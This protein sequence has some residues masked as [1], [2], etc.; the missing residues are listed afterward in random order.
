MRINVSGNNFGADANKISVYVG[1]MPCTSIRLESANIR[2]SCIAPASEKDLEIYVIVD[3]QK[4]ETYYN[5]TYS[6][7]K[8]YLNHTY[9]FYS[10]SLSWSQA[11]STSQAIYYNSKPGYLVSITTK[12]EFDFLVQNFPFNYWSGGNSENGV[13]NWSGVDAN[14]T[15]TISEPY[16][17]TGFCAWNSTL[18][19]NMQY[20]L[21]ISRQ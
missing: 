9:C 11:S 2:L 17:C 6:P 18:D 13:W 10:R 14:V 12:A 1:G 7:A 3:G 16:G 21:Q 15:F 20:A 8:T 4:S 19:S 5:V